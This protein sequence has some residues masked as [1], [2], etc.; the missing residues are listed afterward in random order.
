MKHM[1]TIWRA[2]DLIASYS[3]CAWPIWI[4][5][6]V[7]PD[8]VAPGDRHFAGKFQWLIATGSTANKVLALLSVTPNQN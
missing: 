7:K 4:D 8:L 2:D 3:L 5:H 1:G 6:V